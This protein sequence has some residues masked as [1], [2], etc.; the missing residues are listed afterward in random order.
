M[1]V[2]SA[3]AAD[4]DMDIKIRRGVQRL[5][6]ARHI[7]HPAN[8]IFSDNAA[9]SPHTHHQAGGRELRI[10]AQRFDAPLFCSRRRRSSIGILVSRGCRTQDDRHV[11]LSRPARAT[12]RTCL[13]FY[14]VVSA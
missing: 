9:K 4:E 8:P 1:S 10:A 11:R 6:H 12:A 7:F 14:A 3:I 5:R 2:R 13:P